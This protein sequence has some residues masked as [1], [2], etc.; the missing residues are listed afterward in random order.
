M[1]LCPGGNRFKPPGQDE[2]SWIIKSNQRTNE[3]NEGAKEKRIKQL[4][5]HFSSR[6]LRKICI[7][8]HVFWYKSFIMKRDFYTKLLEWKKSE[9]RKPLILKGAR[10]VGKTYILKEFGKNEYTN[11]AYFN[12]EEDPTLKDFFMGRLQP[13]R[14]LEKLSIY[15]ETKILPHKTLIVSD[16]IQNSPQALT[17]L[18]YFFENA[19]DYHVTAAGS[20]LGLKLGHASPFPVG[21]V[22]F[23]YLYPLVPPGYRSLRSNAGSFCTNHRGG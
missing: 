4:R 14:I 16:E 5:A 22:N 19:N 12:F 17:S 15:Y 9:D 7:K 18:K 23:L 2:T 13:E 3:A 1:P 8:F 21:M 6:F 10:Q 20:L 11:T